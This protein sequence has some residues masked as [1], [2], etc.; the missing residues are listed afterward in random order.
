[1]RLIESVALPVTGGKKLYGSAERVRAQLAR[2]RVRPEPNEPPR[3]L[4]RGVRVAAGRHAGWPV[5]EVTPRPARRR[6]AAPPP[7]LTERD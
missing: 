2:H 4:S 7:A 5:Y 6:P 1:M 3:W